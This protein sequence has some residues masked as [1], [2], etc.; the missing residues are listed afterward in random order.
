LNVGR[1]GDKLTSKPT[2][3]A[4]DPSLIADNCENNKDTKH[5]EHAAKAF[6]MLPAPLHEVLDTV[7]EH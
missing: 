5:P 2:K 7:R 4:H 1:H 3:I 6:P